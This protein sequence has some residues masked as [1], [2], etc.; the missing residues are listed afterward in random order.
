NLLDWKTKSVERFFIY[1]FS[2]TV[3]FVTTNLMAT[4][5]APFQLIFIVGALF[6]DEKR[7]PILSGIF[8]GLSIIDPISMFYM[9]TTMAIILISTKRATALIWTSITVFLMT[10]FSLI[11]E[12]NWVLSWL[13]SLFLTPSRYPF[14]SFI[15][16]ASLKYNFQ[17]NRIFTVIP[18]LLISWVLFELIRTPKDTIEKKIWIFSITGILNHYL[19][20]Q[21]SPNSEILFLFTMILLIAI[22][23]D[24]VKQKAKIALYVLVGILSY[25]V[26]KWPLFN[27]YNNNELILS[28]ISLFFLINLY[29]IRAWVM[30]PYYVNTKDKNIL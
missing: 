14:L 1:L 9:L 25:S 16:S 2:I 12:R 23:W 11:F 13:K 24:K 29:W 22:W 8:F 15:K 28:F 26:Y 20:V 18:I 17:F 27:L 7:K 30:K 6:F 10:L 19:M 3:F 21:P 5:I 4:N